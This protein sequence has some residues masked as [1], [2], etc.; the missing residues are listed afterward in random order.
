MFM[1]KAQPTKNDF[2]GT[3]S[4]HKMEYVSTISFCKNGR[5]YFNETY[6]G[7]DIFKTGLYNIVK[8]EAFL[9]EDAFNDVFVV[10][11]LANKKVTVGRMKIN[12]FGTKSMLQYL[13]M[14]FDNKFSRRNLIS[15][16]KLIDNKDNSFSIVLPKVSHLYLIHKN[17]PTQLFEFEIPQN[18]NDISILI[19]KFGSWGD[20][21][22]NVFA[23][24][25]TTI[26]V[27]RITSVLTGNT[28]DYKNDIV[29]NSNE[30]FTKSKIEMEKELSEK[31]KLE[32][33]GYLNKGKYK[34]LLRKNIVVDETLT[35][36]KDDNIENRNHVEV[37]TI[38]QQKKE[39]AL[40][41]T[42]INFDENY[43][44]KKNKN[45]VKSNITST[46]FTNDETVNYFTNYAEALAAAKKEKKYVL[47]FSDTLKN[48]K[49][50]NAWKKDIALLKDNATNINKNILVYIANESDTVK[51]KNWGVK[52]YPAYAI[53]NGDDSIVQYG[54]G[55]D[56]YR[57]LSQFTSDYNDNINFDIHCFYTYFPNKIEKAN[58]DST[59]VYQ[60]FETCLA[61]KKITDGY[62]S[63]PSL[64]DIGTNKEDE[65]PT[66]F[67]SEL[68][69]KYPAKTIIELTDNLLEKNR[70]T[71]KADKKTI[72]MVVS[73]IRTALS[74][75]YPQ[76]MLEDIYR[77]K[78]NSKHYGP[79]NNSYPGIMTPSFQFIFANYE[80]IKNY[81]FTDNYRMAKDS[82][83]I[84]QFLNEVIKTL[85]KQNEAT[86]INKAIYLL[87]KGIIGE[88][89][90][91]FYHI[92]T[93]L[94]DNF[95]YRDT[96][97]Q[98]DT[99]LVKEAIENFAVLDNWKFKLNEFIA[100]KAKGT[101]R[102]EKKVIN[103]AANAM[104][105]IAD[106]N[107]AERTNIAK[108][109]AGYASVLNTYSRYVMEQN[110]DSYYKNI[111]IKWSEC[112]ME[113]AK[114]TENEFYYVDTY[115]RLLDAIGRRRDAIVMERKA[116][117][118]ASKNEYCDK[119]IKSN[120]LAFLNVMMTSLPPTSKK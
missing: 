54:W 50:S 6:G 38:V 94:N 87:H 72:A 105:N 93:Y 25:D 98:K 53:V 33:F 24:F 5:F 109:K 68:N 28:R 65:V 85:T 81:L 108:I 99:S 116:I 67:D 47:I 83:T 46:I 97:I 103:Y 30:V 61:Y 18:A 56:L 35:F 15:F 29:D 36:E 84:Y 26:N 118:M 14:S 27:L 74:Q 96:S 86:K 119:N 34:F 13:Y 114:N 2:V 20:W 16:I 41:A 48:G 100:S 106:L 82:I 71:V 88:S 51:L 31:F 112:S 8:G 77:A 42:T 64:I 17:N 120:M 1:T 32:N 79:I 44:D 63:S 37:K 55:N 69:L 78:S 57:K 90:L 95:I 12:F 43:F 89:A 39:T 9:E 92:P 52:N 7:V 59:L 4:S 22:N 117:V 23:S 66:Y 58:F 40:A 3:F 104:A 62:A 101:I 91:A 19:N 76:Y 10:G 45:N 115:A 110:M 49:I 21:Q 70:N 111:A 75:N 102:N 73:N 80:V 107:Y 11:T 60:F 113:L